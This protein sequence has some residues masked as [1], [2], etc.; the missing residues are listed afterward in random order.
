M[1]AL[2]LEAHIRCNGIFGNA[3]R[4]ILCSI[5]VLASVSGLFGTTALTRLFGLAKEI[6]SLSLLPRHIASALA[7]GTA[8]IL[9]PEISLILCMR[10]RDSRRNLGLMFCRRALS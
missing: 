7:I 5:I 9:G 8:S 2:D 3:T 4:P 10:L 6:A 1:D